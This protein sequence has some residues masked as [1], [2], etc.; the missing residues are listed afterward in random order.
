M[1]IDVKSNAVDLY[2]GIY[3]KTKLTNLIYAII[4]EYVRKIE[5]GIHVA[6]RIVLYEYVI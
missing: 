5:E 1:Y 3:G 4:H 2:A 6:Y